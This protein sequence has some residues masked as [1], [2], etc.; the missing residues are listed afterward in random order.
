MQTIGR[1]M[2]GDL[3]LLQRRGM[4]PK[5]AVDAL[6]AEAKERHPRSNAVVIMKS[7]LHDGFDII[8]L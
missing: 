4:T 1:I 5:Q 8:A 7:A 2:L 6:L 3:G